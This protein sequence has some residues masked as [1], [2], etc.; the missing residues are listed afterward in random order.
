M[1]YDAQMFCCCAISFLLL[2]SGD[3]LES[4]IRRRQQSEEEDDGEDTSS[5]SQEFE[6]VGLREEKAL[7]DSEIKVYIMASSTKG[8]LTHCYCA[9]IYIEWLL[10]F[11]SV[12]LALAF[13]ISLW[14]NIYWQ[15]QS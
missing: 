14:Y 6:D 1:F 10:D 9:S 5:S 15:P 2:C 4:E 7:S 11:G 8:V 12:L 3:P 13:V